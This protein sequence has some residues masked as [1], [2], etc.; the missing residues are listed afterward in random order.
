MNRRM[1]IN[2]DDFGLCEGV[3]RAVEHAHKTGVLTSATIMAGFSAAEEA[4]EIASRCPDLGVGVHLNL[5]EGRPVSQDDR[6]KTLTNDQGEFAFSA[7]K[8]AM[9]SLLKKQSRE[10]I[11]TEL[12]SQVQWVIDRGIKPTHLDSH[13]HVHTFPA[14]YP[15]VVR[16]AGRFGIPAIRWPYEPK[17]VCGIAWPLPSDKGRIRASIVR[18]MAVINKFQNDKIIKN[19]MFFGIAHT[20]K[21]DVDFIRMAASVCP[22]GVVELMTHPG[23]TDGLDPARTRLVEQRVG[24]LKALCSEQTKDIIKEHKITLTHYGKL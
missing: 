5:L 10:A 20:G 8:L 23:Y 24:E 12:I 21:I 22:K 9:I 16:I 2:A 18:K 13:K 6:V 11:E 17:V 3:N 19:N 15:I 7:S 4:I 1:I 14:I